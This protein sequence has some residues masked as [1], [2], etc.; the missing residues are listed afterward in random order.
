MAQ[1]LVDGPRNAVLKVT[2]A[3]TID[4]SALSGAP[5]R[6]SIEKIKYDAGAATDV[7]LS[8]DAT[9]DSL[10]TPLSHSNELCFE[11][12]GGLQNDEA[13]GATGDIVV[14][15]TPPFM[16]VLYLKKKW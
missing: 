7:K 6:V 12:C 8:W 4:V 2:A 11:D 10:I 9:A 5:S 14:A 13:A 16:A 15:G 3:E 1:I